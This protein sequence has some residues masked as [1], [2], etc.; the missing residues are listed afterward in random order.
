MI[1]KSFLLS[2]VALATFSQVQALPTD[3]LRRIARRQDF[4]ALTDQ[5]LFQDS[6]ETFINDRRNPKVYEPHL[7]WDSD[8]CSVPP[9]LEP[10]VGDKDKP[11][12]NDFLPSCH[13]HDFGYRNYKNQGRF[14]AENRK[15]VDDKFRADMLEWCEKNRNW[16][17]K[18]LCKITA[19]TYY[20]AV[21][22]CGGGS[23]NV[24]G[25]DLADD[26]SVSAVVANEPELTSF[27]DG[28]RSVGV[29]ITDTVPDT[30]AGDAVDT[31]K[32]VVDHLNPS[33]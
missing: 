4:T 2:L 19:N 32:D 28:M 30:A 7:L 26:E 27:L 33:N 3:S 21:R 18:E 11:Y 29:D 24:G 22:L 31:V 14:T 6:I 15:K 8:G 23:C 13:R 1:S 20:G 5:F 9:Q 12:G 10:V 17:A 25:L 16:P